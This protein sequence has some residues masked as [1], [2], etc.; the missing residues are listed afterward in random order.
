MEPSV[1]EV[2]AWACMEDVMVWA[3]LDGAHADKGTPR[4][5]LLRVLG[6]TGAH[7]AVRGKGV[8][9][10]NA[11]RTSRS[12]KKGGGFNPLPKKAARRSHAFGYGYSELCGVHAAL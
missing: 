5:S 7:R 12:P 2:A 6:V 1:A 9:P 4:G 10:P 11:S 8:L 3:Q